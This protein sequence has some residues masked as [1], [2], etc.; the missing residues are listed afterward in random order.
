[1]LRKSIVHFLEIIKAS[2]AIKFSIKFKHEQFQD[3]SGINHG[4]FFLLK[5]FIFTDGAAEN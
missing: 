5:A 1:L 2:G 4:T 3:V